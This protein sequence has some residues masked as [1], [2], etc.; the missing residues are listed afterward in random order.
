[1]V[2]GGLTTRGH[3]GAFRGFCAGGPAEAPHPHP[4]PTE[5]EGRRLSVGGQAWQSGRKWQLRMPPA[6]IFGDR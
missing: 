3:F 4:L 6:G 2:I 1:M 5:G